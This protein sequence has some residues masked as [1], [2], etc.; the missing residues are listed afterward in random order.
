MDILYEIYD[1]LSTRELA[2][3]TL[4]G[5]FLIW[6]VCYRS[7]RT[8]I[9][10]ILNSIFS[11]KILIIILMLYGWIFFACYIINL[12]GLWDNQYIKDVI[13]F[14]LSTT[15]VL[16]KVTE[17]KSQ[18]DFGILII[19]HI[20]YAAFISVY[21][22]LYT[23]GYLCEI[24]LQFSICIIVL[25]KSVI[26]LQNEKYN[27]T[28][29]LY[30]CLNKCNIAFGYFILLF[31]LYQTCIHPLAYTLEMIL[32]GIALPF[33]FTIIVT[34]YLYCFTI[35][36]SYEMWFIRL[37]RSVCD[38]KIEYVRRRNL[39]IRH[40]GLN[41]RKLKYFEQRI[42]LFA[43]CDYNEFLQTIKVCELEYRKV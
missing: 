17:Y 5:L 14:S 28:K 25:M 27:A 37:K 10:Q 29:Q 31:I 7:V 16:M 11:P 30:G 34:P 1:S 19:E 36:G 23:L 26:E 2:S 38:E 42:K 40:C 22:N 35:Y 12:I 43:I 33:I 24:L 8:S 4:L 32:I 41:L 21:L 39:L 9:L 15:L 3:I 6:M 13:L 20:K 18:Q